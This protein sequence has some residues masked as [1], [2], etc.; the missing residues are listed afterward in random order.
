MAFTYSELKT[1]IQDYMEND[2]TTFTNSLDTFIK[3]TEERILKEVELLGF[4]KN[5]TGT[6]TSDSPYLGMPTDYLAPFSLAVI[7]S[8]SNYNY[9]LLKHV[10]FIREYTPAAAT[11]GTPLYYAQFD[12]DSFILAPTPSAALTMELHYFY[13]PSSLTAG[14]DSGTTYISTYAPDALL[15]GSLLEAAVFM[16]LGAEEFSIYQDRY[17]REMVRLKNWSEGKNTRTE[18]RYDRI[19][20]QPS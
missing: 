12:E 19:R 8:D 11:T 10:S 13:Q 1:A 16:K 6:L 14:A 18:D 20:S 9:L 7:D 15:Y 5:V 3:N 4:R 17:D 2:E